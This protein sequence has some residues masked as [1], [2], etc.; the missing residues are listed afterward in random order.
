MR[1]RSGMSLVELVVAMTILSFVLLAMSGMF[2]IISRRSTANEADLR[3]AAY[4]QQAASFF[5]TIPFDSIPL[6]MPSNTFTDSAKI[7]EVSYYVL[8]ATYRDSTVPTG[9]SAMRMITV[10]VTPR[11]TRRPDSL[12]IIR[13]KPSCKSVLNTGASAC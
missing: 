10:R 5:E 4:L 1:A 9:A 6:R 8:Q 7:D 11:R 13:A 2:V 3:R 12:R